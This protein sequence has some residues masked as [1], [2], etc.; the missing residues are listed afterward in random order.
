MV[1]K[2]CQPRF[3]LI[4][5]NRPEKWYALSFGPGCSVVPPAP[6]LVYPPGSRSDAVS[7]SPRVRC[8]F[9]RCEKPPSRRKAPV[10]PSLS[11]VTRIPARGE[12]LS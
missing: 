4:G 1:L 7:T 3:K 9:S 11:A 8:V 2:Q 6:R 10:R 5:V 12:R